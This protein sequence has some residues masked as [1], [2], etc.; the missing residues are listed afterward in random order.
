[1]LLY[2]AIDI[3]GGHAVRLTQGD[4]SRETVFDAGTRSP[5]M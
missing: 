1:M 2:P 5:S 3:R 4:Y